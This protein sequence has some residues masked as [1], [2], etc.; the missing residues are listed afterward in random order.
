MVCLREC[1]GL[2]PLGAVSLCPLVK[3]FPLAILLAMQSPQAKYLRPGWLSRLLLPRRLPQCQSLRQWWWCLLSSWLRQL[4]SLK[5]RRKL[6]PQLQRPG[7]RHSS[8]KR[9]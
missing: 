3:P 4:W 9:C 6:R 1:E 5:R 7:L 8:C 2:L